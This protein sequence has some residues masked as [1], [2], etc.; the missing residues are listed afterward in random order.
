MAADLTGV[1]RKIARAKDKLD[2]LSKEVA[3]YFDS[4][5]FRL[6]EEANGNHYAVVSYIDQ[7]PDQE[8][9]LEI[10]EIATQARSALDHL[11]RQLI[12]DSGNDPNRSKRSQFPIF[13][14]RDA[15]VNKG[16]RRESHRDTML[17]GVAA[18]HRDLIDQFQP[19]QRGRRIDDDPLCILD[20]VSNRDKHRDVHVALAAVGG[21]RFKLA[22]PDGEVL[23]IRINVADRPQPIVDG[24]VVIG[25]TN[26][27][28]ADAPNQKVEMLIEDISMDL[29]FE[30]DR[31]LTVDDMDRA[32]LHASG[33]IDR[34]AKRIKPQIPS[35]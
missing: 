29:F 19:Y 8:W 1:R 7:E 17:K 30:G 23:T 24:Q 35:A 9:G 32:V 2:A 3:A 12:I 28:P 20:A 34:L 15:Y 16:R 4:D 6:V 27:P 18:R 21:S 22:K 10:A 14:N 33:I 11:I 13:R 26:N 25:I 31:F 5:P